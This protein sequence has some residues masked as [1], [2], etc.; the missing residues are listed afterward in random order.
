MYIACRLDT[1]VSATTKKPT[2]SDG[3]LKYAQ[4]TGLKPVLREIV[5]LNLNTLILIIINA[6][7]VKRFIKNTN[8]GE[9]VSQLCCLQKVQS[10]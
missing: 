9:N 10:K 6:N 2:Q 7:D 5:E 8:S 4:M 1:P 3:I